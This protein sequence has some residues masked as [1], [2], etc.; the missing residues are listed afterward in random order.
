MITQATAEQA[1]DGSG[2]GRPR[3]DRAIKEAGLGVGHR[4]LSC[5][6]QSGATGAKRE[7]DDGCENVFEG[8][9]LILF[10]EFMVFKKS[11]KFSPC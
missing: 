2:A 6:V 11:L 3:G 7:S 4:G 10:A 9:L 8:E 5:E 1:H